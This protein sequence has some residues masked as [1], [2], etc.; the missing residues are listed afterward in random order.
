M[1]WLL[2][3]LQD[4]GWWFDI[5]I[6]G[7]IVSALSGFLKDAISRWLANSSEWYRNRR[8]KALAMKE[9]RTEVLASHPDLLILESVVAVGRM[10]FVFLGIGL[11]LAGAA[12]VDMHSSPLLFPTEE[13]GRFPHGRIVLYKTGVVVMGVIVFYL[14]FT[15]TSSIA[16]ILRAERRLHQR[17]LDAYSDQRM[18]DNITVPPA[19]SCGEGPIDR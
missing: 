15:T 6:V 19:E 10:L 4:P 18:K 2:K 13:L 7:I 8:A 17:L 11:T 5:F 3:R 1:E 12:L 16:E 9:M 14:G